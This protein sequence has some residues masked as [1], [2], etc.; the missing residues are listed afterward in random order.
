MSISDSIGDF[1]TLIRNASSVGKPHCVSGFSKV[2]LG[3][4]EVLKSEG[5]IKGYESITREGFEAL[6]VDLKYAGTVALI[7]GIQRYSRP[8]CR[9]Y[10]KAGKLPRVLNGLGI[11][12]VTSSKGIFS[13]VEAAKHGV[14]GEVICKVW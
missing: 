12:I 14:G 8:G 6:R 1:L 9:L 2:K 4:A 10:A 3:I 11:C 7:V 5:Y 13:N